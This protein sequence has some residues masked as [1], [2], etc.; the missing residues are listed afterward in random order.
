MDRIKELRLQQKLKQD[1]IAKALQLN[2]RTYQRY[3]RGE[4]PL[5]SSISE[6][7]ASYYNVSIDYLL[8]YTNP[9]IEDVLDTSDRAQMAYL[10]QQLGIDISQL[11]LFMSFCAYLRSQK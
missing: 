2:L 3:E 10:V 5:P 11:D 9:A 8:G 7:L 4:T 6:K 1:E